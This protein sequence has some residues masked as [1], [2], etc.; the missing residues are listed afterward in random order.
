MENKEIVNGIREYLF[1]TSNILSD[2]ENELPEGI[3]KLLLKNLHN[4][5]NEEFSRIVVVFENKLEFSDSNEEKIILIEQMEEYV[6]VVD[7]KI[8]EILKGVF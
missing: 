4:K 3:K 2:I 7:E 6:K 1:S 5:L 8:R